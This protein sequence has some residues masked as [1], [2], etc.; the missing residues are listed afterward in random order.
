MKMNKL[1]FWESEEKKLKSPVHNTAIRAFASL[2]IILSGIAPISD[3][4]ITFELA[5]NFGFSDTS[6]FV[7][8]TSQTLAPILMALGAFLKP[9]RISYLVPIYLFTVQFIWIFGT[10]Y[11]FDDALL[12]FYAIGIVICFL[13]LVITINSL[14]SIAFKR[15]DSK[16]SF[17]E[18]AL[19][20]S[21]DLNKRS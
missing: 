6:T 10:S 16:M 20:L 7:W 19:D 14:F 4:V 5:N 3:K 8:T 11:E 18:K 15:Q 2:L 21:I 1:R 13:I 17:L 9:Y 12:H